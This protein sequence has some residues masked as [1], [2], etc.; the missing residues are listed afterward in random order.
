[1]ANG[2][3]ITNSICGDKR[4]NQLSSDTSRMAF[5]WLVTFADREGR[6]HGDPAMVRSMLFPRR[7]DVTIEAMEAM[8]LEWFC[9]GLIVWYEENGDL[10]IWFPSFEKNQ[11]GLRKD[12]E[13][14]S[15]IPAPTDKGTELVRTRYGVSTEQLPVKRI[16]EKRIEGDNTPEIDLYREVTGLV[17]DYSHEEEVKR[18]VRAIQE[19]H[20]IPRDEVKR[21]MEVKFS[22]WCAA[23][24]PEGKSY[25]PSNPKWLEWCVT[26]YSPKPVKANGRAKPLPSGV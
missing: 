25:N 7:Q 9:L 10:W 1:M 13:A 2:R 5:T 14:P 12:K 18:N 19:K 17:P 16:E 23:R 15:K 24:T 6:T 8:I 20:H 3:M 4:I 26:G 22:E 21:M 11:P